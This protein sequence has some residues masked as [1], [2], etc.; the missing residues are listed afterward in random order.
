LLGCIE[1]RRLQL[2]VVSVADLA[3]FGIEEY[4]NR[5]SP[6]QVDAEFASDIPIAVELANV[7]GHEMEHVIS[8]CSYVVTLEMVVQRS[9]VD[10]PV[11]SEGDHQKSAALQRFR[12]ARG[13][14][15][16]GIRFGVVR[17]VGGVEHGIRTRIIEKVIDEL[18]VFLLEFGDELLLLIEVLL[19]DDGTVTHP[20]GRENRRGAGNGAAN[21]NQPRTV[22]RVIAQK[23]APGVGKA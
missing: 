14:R 22:F 11:C 18:L 6:V 7:D 15:G 10:T 4:G 20:Q 23:V 5:Y 1:S 8:E 12:A 13:Y 2:S 21:K 16:A 3:P 9:A 17:Q 19:V